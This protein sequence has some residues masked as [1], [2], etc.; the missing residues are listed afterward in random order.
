MGAEIRQKRD[1]KGASMK[2]PP[3][4]KGNFGWSGV[5]P[6]AGASMKAP[7][8]RKGNEKHPRMVKW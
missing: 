4:R 5:G 1:R 3:K 7:P 6:V 8:K 2:A